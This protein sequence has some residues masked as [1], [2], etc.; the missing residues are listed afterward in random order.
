MRKVFAV[1]FTALLGASLLTACSS[2]PVPTGVTIGWSDKTRTAVQ[3]SWKDS[4][5]PNRITIQGVVST[6]PS[7]VKYLPATEPNTWAIPASAFPPDGN[8]KIAVEIG[9]SIGGVSSKAALSPMFDTDGPLRP[10]DAIATPTGKDVVVSWKV[11]PPEQDFSPGDPLDVPHDS[12][13]YVPIVGS[14]GQPF[15]V[16]GPGTT[17]TR[18]VVKNLRPPYYFQL[19][20]TNEWTSLTGAEIAGRTSSTSTGVPTLWTFGS[21]MPIRGRTVQQQISCAESRCAVQQTSSAGLPVVL[22]AQSK[23]GGPWVQVG[24]STTQ[25]GGYF[26]IRV[27]AAGTRNYRAYV[28]LTSRVG[29]LTTP[30]SSKASLSRSRIQIASA[31]YAGGNVH[32]RNDVVTATL[33]VRPAMNQ[34]AIFQFWNGKAWA[35]IKEAPIRNGRASIAFKAVRPGTFAYRFLVPGTQYQGTSV[36]G[37]ATASMVLRVR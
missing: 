37:T 29:A 1:A 3:V 34:A 30:S 36:Y 2:D 20:A 35:S 18:Q 5:A 21:Q 22:L 32:N 9:T 33:G 25:L 31:G 4:D 27:I 28:P 19:R 26:E 23:A 16:V 14:A 24:R 8:Y 10:S 15:R 12:Q 17:T 11:P 7:Y 6:S 13:L